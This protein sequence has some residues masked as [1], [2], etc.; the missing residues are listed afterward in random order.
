MHLIDIIEAA[1]KLRMIPH[2][3]GGLSSDVACGGHELTAEWGAAL[4]V[5]VEIAPK[6]LLVPLSLL[7]EDRSEEIPS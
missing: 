2:S 1:Y 7:G 5:I 6:A 4:R 3:L